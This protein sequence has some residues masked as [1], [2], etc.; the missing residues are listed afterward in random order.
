MGF[1]D[2]V[3]DLAAQ[4]ADKVEAAIE[5]VG[6]IVDEKTD[7]KFKSVVDSAQE[8]AKKAVAGEQP[9][10]APAPPAEGTQEQQ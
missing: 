2:K 1:L 6:D 7:G 9:A 8:A 10:E 4:N 5:K 3:K